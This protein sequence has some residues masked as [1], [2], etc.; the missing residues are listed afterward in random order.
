M[1]AEPSKIVLPKQR[2]LERIAQLHIKLGLITIVVVNI[3]I[4]GG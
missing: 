4:H 1:P 3:I 2:D